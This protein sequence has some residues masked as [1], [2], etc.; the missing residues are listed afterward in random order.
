MKIELFTRARKSTIYFEVNY[1]KGRLRV[2][3]ERTTTSSRLTTGVFSEREK[4]TRRKPR[5]RETEKDRRARQ[6]MMMMVASFFSLV[7]LCISLSL[8]VSFPSASSRGHSRVHSN[9]RQFFARLYKLDLNV[10]YLN[11]HNGIHHRHRNWPCFYI[12]KH[13]LFFKIK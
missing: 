9:R 5:E 11:L 12:L 7:L 2:T 3:V 6:M 4:K 10:K 8:C 13:L 1:S